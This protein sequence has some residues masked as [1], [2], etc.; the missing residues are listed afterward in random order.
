ML[1][2]NH[3][4]PLSFICPRNITQNIVLNEI[5]YHFIRITPSLTM[6]SEKLRAY[7]SD[8]HHVVDFKGVKEVYTGGKEDAYM[9]YMFATSLTNV[10]KKF[11]K[12]VSSSQTE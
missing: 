8:L 11:S 6:A 12:I 9:A 5:V 7:A 2:Y 1:G 3:G 10:A 4:P